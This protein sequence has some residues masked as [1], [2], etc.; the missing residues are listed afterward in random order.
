MTQGVSSTAL[1]SVALS[2]TPIELAANLFELL[3][4]PL[5]FVYH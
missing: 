5:Y 3:E 4:A 2:D 1:Q